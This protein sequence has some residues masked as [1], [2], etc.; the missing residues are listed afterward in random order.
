MIFYVDSSRAHDRFDIDTANIK[1]HSDLPI[2]KIDLLR[3]G[4][5]AEVKKSKVSKLCET[6]FRYFS[7]SGTVVIAL[8]SGLK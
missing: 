4:G 5:G 2:G 3:F 7:T 1:N 6:I 8:F